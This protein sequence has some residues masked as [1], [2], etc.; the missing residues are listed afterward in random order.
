MFL[1]GLLCTIS[2]CEARSGDLDQ[3]KGKEYKHLVS[4]IIC[5]MADLLPSC[6]NAPA[7]LFSPSR[8]K[9]PAGSIDNWLY[10][11]SII[12]GLAPLMPKEA[13]C[14]FSE[15]HQLDDGEE[16]EYLVKFIDTLKE[17]GMRVFFLTFR[18]SE[19]LKGKLGDGK[20]A[21]LGGAN[22]DEHLSQ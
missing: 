6:F 11:L 8:F 9:D 21:P 3:F 14:V 13:T 2:S 10:H 18:A 20:V 16:D 4:T 19:A 15:F 17:S 5:Q 7:G 22:P 1:T 12:R